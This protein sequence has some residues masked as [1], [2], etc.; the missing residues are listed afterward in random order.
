MDIQAAKDFA[1]TKH[2]E[3]SEVFKFDEF[4]SEGFAITPGENTND[5]QILRMAITAEIDAINLY[6]QMADSA[7]DKRIKLILLDVAKEEKDTY[8]RV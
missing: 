6:E 8:C 1:S 2:D 7:K 5:A 4:V 3:L